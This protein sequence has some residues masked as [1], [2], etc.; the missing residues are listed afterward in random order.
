[1]DST[2]TVINLSK[3]ERVDLSKN[4]PGLDHLAAGLSWDANQAANGPTFDLDAFAL[5]L[6][7]GKLFHETDGLMYFN[8]QSILNGAITSSGDNLT[9][10]GDGDD[11]TVNILL[12]KLPAD[13][14]E[15]LIAVNIYDAAG[16]HENFGQVSSA[17]IRLYNAATNTELMKYDLSEDYSSFTGVLM[18]KVYRKDGEWKFTAVGTGFNGSIADFANTYL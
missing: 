4:N 14:E 5:V 7:G 18:G 12:S 1:M 16:K 9:G 2:A 3:G 13:A 11:E 10:A 15:V 8:R 17:A 6:K